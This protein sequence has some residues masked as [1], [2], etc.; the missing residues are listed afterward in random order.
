[1]EAQVSSGYNELRHIIDVIY[2]LFHK[3]SK[4]KLATP[5]PILQPHNVNG[6]Q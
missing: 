1:M 2:I 3:Q 5:V 6:K 4:V